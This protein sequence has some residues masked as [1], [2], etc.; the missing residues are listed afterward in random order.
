MIPFQPVKTGKISER[1]ARQIKDTILSGSM[2]SGDRLPPE[3]EL[4][5][6][7]QASRISIREA[8][9]SLETSGL[10]A[11]KPGSGVFVAEVNSKPMSESLSSIL[12]IQK[13]SINELTE[14]R[15]ILEP[16]IARLAAER[17]TPE[18]FLKLEQNIEDTLMILKSDSPAPEQ[19]IRFHSLI[20]EATHNPVITS[21]MNPIFDVLKEMNL[22]IKDNLPTRLELSRDALEYHKKILKAFR[23]KNSQKIYELMLKHIF[24]NQGGLKKV[25]SATQTLPVSPPG[26]GKGRGEI[27]N[28]PGVGLSE[29]ETSH[30]GR[31]GHNGLRANLSK[32]EEK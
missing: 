28:I 15:I 22:E 2:K 31:I 27:S 30:K 11:I 29:R 4:V 1:I 26:R 23:E 17:M 32:E 10:L 14:A 3:R 21:T 9:K 5:G 12:R 16:S 6:H 18:E 19:N 13:T 24:Q 25:T 20:A 8:L 7:F